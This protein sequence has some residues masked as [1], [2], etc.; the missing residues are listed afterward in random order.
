MCLVEDIFH[1]ESKFI[2]YLQYIMCCNKQDYCLAIIIITM[3]I[4][5]LKM[6]FS[7]VFLLLFMETSESCSH[8]EPRA[9][10]TVY[11]LIPSYI[12][13]AHNIVCVYFY[14]TNFEVVVIVNTTTVS[15]TRSMLRFSTTQ[16]L[17]IIST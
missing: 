16:R 15:P 2:L 13:Q 17:I 10:F 9:T 11:I 12:Y 3:H 4:L 5:W 1:F 14:Q 6:V 7:N 8:P